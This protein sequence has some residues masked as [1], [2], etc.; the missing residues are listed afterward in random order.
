M[1]QIFANVAYPTGPYVLSVNISAGGIPKLPQTSALAL[2]EGLRGDGRNH[3]KHIRPDRAVSLW[4]YEILRALVAEGFSSLMPGAAGENLTVAGLKVQSMA[5]GALLKIGDAVL[6][7]EQF[8][9]PC[10]VLDAI[11]PRLKDV[12]IGRIGF[13]ASVVREGVIRPEMPIGVIDAC[14]ADHGHN[15][16]PVHPASDP[17][18]V[19]PGSHAFHLLAGP[20]IG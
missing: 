19:L 9:K 6:K 1:Q 4:D 16:M 12:V 15:E 13:L 14:A 2:K 3:T 10:Y 17:L 11:D 18:E 5:P 7:L 8:R 20:T